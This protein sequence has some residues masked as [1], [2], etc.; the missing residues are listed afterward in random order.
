MC[1]GRGQKTCRWDLRVVVNQLQLLYWAVHSNFQFIFGRWVTPL[2]RV[3]FR[4]SNTNILDLY[5][6]NHYIFVWTLKICHFHWIRFL[7]GSRHLSLFDRSFKKTYNLAYAQMKGFL[8]RLVAY[9]NKIYYLC[10]MLI[11]RF[12]FF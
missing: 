9:Q 7:G 6:F 3:A 11:S 5:I 8:E 4:T 12:P 10:K 2:R 1:A